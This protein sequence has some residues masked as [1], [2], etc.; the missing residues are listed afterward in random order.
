VVVVTGGSVG[1]VSCGFDSACDFKVVSNPSIIMSM[2]LIFIGT[3]T[4]NVG[5]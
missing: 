2:R 3:S 5:E 4:D 1:G